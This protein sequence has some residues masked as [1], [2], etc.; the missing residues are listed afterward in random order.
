M[1][2]P[3]ARTTIR[4]LADKAGVSTATVSRMFN[5]NGFVSAEARKKI[6][7]AVKETG[8]DPALRRRR[9]VRPAPGAL[10][11]G[12]AALIWTVREQM[13]PT[14]RDLM[15]GITEGLRQCGAGLQVDQV[16]DGGHIPYPLRNGGIDGV[17]IHGP[18]PEGGILKYLR[19]SPVV[20]LFQQGADDFGDRVQPDHAY[21]GRLACDHLV[22]QGCRNLCCITS[23]DPRMAASAHSPRLLNYVQTRARAFLDQ[24]ATHQVPT[25][26]IEHPGLPS[27]ATPAERAAVGAEMAAAMA[28]VKPRPDGLFV[29]SDLGPHI[30]VELSRLG[31]VPMQ[32]VCM[33]AGDLN[34][35]AQFALSPA[36]ITIRIFSKQIGL[37][38][39]EALLQRIKNPDMPQITCL[40][41]PRLEI[42]GQQ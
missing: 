29:A 14:G 26:V 34:I 23:V 4:D 13:S 30:H 18:A 1:T 9:T 8:Y 22:E 15:L 40:L 42:P 11:H 39:V 27:G 7:L 25:S 16:D 19:K 21:A 38:A 28:G 32:D 10:A 24:A 37:Q 20:W 6:Q 35:C 2:K 17:F 3:T 12:N 33:I 31:V 36:P 41:K 5:D